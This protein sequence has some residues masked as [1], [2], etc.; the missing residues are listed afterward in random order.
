MTTPRENKH[1]RRAES[2]E[3]LLAKAVGRAR[4][5]IA[6]ERAWPILVRIGV[7]AAAFLAVSWAGLWL[8]LPIY[9][10]IAGVALFALALILAAWPLLSFAWPTRRDAIARLDRKSAR[11]H[12]PATAISDALATKPD[13]AVGAA[14]WRAHLARALS[15]ARGLDPGVPAPGVPAKDPRAVRALAL[16]A[17][18]AAFFFAAGDRAGRIGAAFDWRGIAP[19][20]PYRLDAWVDPPAYTGRAPMVLPGLRSEDPTSL[21]ALALQVPSGSVLVVRAAGIDTE[22]L[23]LDG[24]IAEEKPQATAQ[25]AT[26][27]AKPQD[28]KPQADALPARGER[29]FVIRENADVSFLGPDQRRLMWHF[30]VQP[31]TPPSIAF[32]KDPQVGLRNTTVLAYRIEDDYGIKEAD[33]VLVPAVPEAPFFPRPGSSV[34]K[35]AP[36]PLVPAPEVKLTLPSGGRSG[37]AQTTKDL[38]AHPWAGATVA[39]TLK[40]KDEAGNESVSETKTF[41]LPQRAFTKPLA[42]ALVDERRRLAL[43][44]SSRRR[45]VNVL[46]ALTDE[47]QK[48]KPDMSE[49]LGLRT[50]LAMARGARN[51]ADLRALVDY[52]W[53][54]AV[55]IEDG[56][57]TDAERALKAAQEALREA[58]ER[59]ASDEEIRKLTQDLRAAMERMMRQMAEQAMRDRGANDRPLDQNTRIMRPQD[60]QKMLDRIEDLARSGNKEAA[61][62]LLDQLQAMMENMRPGNR[63]AGRGQQG[64]Q[65]QSELG[66]M[67]QEQQRLRDRTFRQGQEGQQGQRGQRGQQGQ[68]G[69]QGE[70]GEGQ[71]GFDQLQQGQQDLRRRLGRMLDQLRRMQPGQQGQ[72][73]GQQGDGGQGQGQEQDDMAR[74]GD[75]LGRAEQAMREAEEA[76]GRGD[77]QGAL[78]AEGRALQA[79][80]QGAQSLAQAQQGNDR[81]PGPGGPG[82]D[83]A[84]RVDP[85]GRPLRSQ[86]YGDDFTVKVPDEVDAQRAR[87]VLEELRRRLEQPMRPQIELDYLERLLKGL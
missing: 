63:Q 81:G 62:E 32:A 29:R 21:N 54:M 59:G 31:D 56:T 20:T 70:N 4:L 74:A 15:A 27:D 38:V 24:G 73:Q 58:L 84:Q 17:L 61:R 37:A 14:L 65:Q 1:P 57:L 25:D 9:G 78:D 26:K 6:W 71:E 42:K 33:A 7:V 77:G 11:A 12:R 76:L 45:L 41:R 67:I 75:Q 8:S 44:P 80:R 18:I 10:R 50:G 86:D 69:R 82:E 85:L 64:Q 23:K 35:V 79:L 52:L 66:A 53:D 5:V 51:D 39:I 72:G 40:A 55:R 49:Y 36:K 87:R 16:L 48:F 60:L 30:K 46:T 83:A 47:P 22:A 13:D 68:Q 43:D 3:G 28:A 19:A 34:P 2:P